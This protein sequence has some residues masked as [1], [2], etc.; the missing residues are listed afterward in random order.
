MGWRKRRQR[1]WK[2]DKEKGGWTKRVVS[3]KQ[4]GTQERKYEG[5]DTSKKDNEDGKCEGIIFER[6][7]FK[8]KKEV[9]DFIRQFE[10]VELGETQGETR[11]KK[12]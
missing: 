3:R 9:W 11:G 6:S 1:K 2:K 8:K 12:K 10:I 5:E 4:R 7:G